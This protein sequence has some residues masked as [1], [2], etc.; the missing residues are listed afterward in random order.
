M[1]DRWPIAYFSEKLN[2]APLNYSVYDRE[3]YSL[4]RALM[5]LQHYLLPKEFIIYIDHESLKHFKGQQHL[6]KCQPK[7]VEFL[8]SFTF[9]IRYKKGNT[10]VVVYAL[11]RRY[12]LITSLQLKLLGFELMKEQYIYDDHLKS[13]VQ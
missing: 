2:S 1:Q 13:I 12:V 6:S 11:S 5:T 9:V 7:W 3:F 4:V 8:E 10:N